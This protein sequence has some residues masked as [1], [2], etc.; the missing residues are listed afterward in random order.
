VA[1]QGR[2]KDTA[3]AWSLWQEPWRFQFFQAVRLLELIYPQRKPVGRDFP[4][5]AV[6]RIDPGPEDSETTAVPQ[7]QVTFLGLSGPAG[8][9]PEGYMDLLLQR[10]REHDHALRDFLDLFNHRTISLFYRAW[11]KYRF[12][13]GFERARRTPDNADLFSFGLEC[14]VGIGTG[15]QKER[16]PFA[17]DALLRYAGHFAHFPRSALMLEIL[18]ADYF[19]IP[20]RIEQ[21]VGRWL[22]LKADER[23]QLPS[24]ECPGGRFNQLG[25]DVVI[26]AQVW[27]VQSGFRIRLGPLAQ[28][29]F[30]QWLPGG[31][32]L[33]RLRSL[34]AMYAGPELDFEVRLVLQAAEVPMCQLGGRS[35]SPA[36]LGWNTWLC[37]A[38]P[39][40]DRADVRFHTSALS[41]E[42][43]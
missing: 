15:H 6:A 3:L 27:D 36:R 18:L 40:D 31:L 19:R 12:P 20:V 22:P 16:L 30:A 17:D 38:A 37:S 14:L 43:A 1:T 39:V 23:T 21:L 13:I 7:M 9:L 42:A 11:E 5:A 26:G 4:A 25:Y 29:Q 34:A 24:P 10:Q 41:L 33:R 35:V 8:V 2:R 28:R 32:H